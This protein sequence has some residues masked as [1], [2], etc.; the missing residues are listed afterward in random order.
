M[1]QRYHEY[2]HNSF[3]NNNGYS[4]QNVNM[5][6]R[7]AYGGKG[8][9][10][11]MS[12]GYNNISYTQNNYNNTSCSLIN[13]NANRYKNQQYNMNNNAFSDNY[14]R[15]CDISIAERDVIQNSPVLTPEGRQF[16]LEEVKKGDDAKERG[17]YAKEAAIHR[18]VQ[19]TLKRN[20]LKQTDDGSQKSYSYNSAIHHLSIFVKDC[21]ELYGLPFERMFN[22]YLNENPNYAIG[23]RRHNYLWK[24]PNKLIWTGGLG[25][26]NEDPLRNTESNLAEFADVLKIKEERKNL[27]NLNLSESNINNMSAMDKWMDNYE[28]KNGPRGSANSYT[29]NT[30]SQ[31]YK[32]YDTNYYVQQNNPNN[33]SAMDRWLDNH[34]KGKFLPNSINHITD[35]YNNSNSNNL[36]YLGIPKRTWN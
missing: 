6:D 11:N 29:N 9:G 2:G 32:N 36:N 24:V 33:M 31:R 4:G 13:H 15:M 7:N 28:K 22:Y 34:K 17:D 35:N 14:A 21:T 8:R 5:S 25:V 19:E 1:S 23:E 20:G 30:Q 10:Q 18:T 26:E 12:N 27:K 16:L 3:N